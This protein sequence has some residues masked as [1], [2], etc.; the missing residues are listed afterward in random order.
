MTENHQIE[1]QRKYIAELAKKG[2]AI[3]P[4]G[5]MCGSCAYKYNS[6][7]NL[8][9]HN[10]EAAAEAA[11]FGQAVFNCHKNGYEDAGKRCVGFLHAR[12]YVEQSEKL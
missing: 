7:A 3:K 12:Q 5:R 10:V 8:E 4:L 1:H 9:P 6:A 11:I 2:A